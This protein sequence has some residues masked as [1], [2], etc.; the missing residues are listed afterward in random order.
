MRVRVAGVGSYVP[1]VVVTNERLVKAIPGWPAERIEEKTGI[2]ERRY[3]YDFDAEA[4]RSIHPPPSDGPGP[5]VQIAELALRDAL[6]MAG[7][8]GED[9]DG[10][11]MTTCNPDRVHFSQD[12]MELHE[13]MGMRP[14]A[15]ALLHDDGCGGAMFHLARAR[16]L[17][18]SGHRRTIAVVGSNAFSPHL[19]RQ[20][21]SGK[22]ERNGS[23]IGSFLSFYLF[24]DG[25][26]AILLRGGSDEGSPSG[27][28]GSYAANVRTDL[29]MNPGGGNHRLPQPGRSEVTDFAFY[30]DGKLVA[31]TFGPF[32]RKAM[33]GALEKAGV[34]LD[35]I[36]RFYVHQ[37]N[38][39]VLEAFVK[40]N[41]IAMDRVPTHM[42][43]YGNMVSAG[44]LVLLAED[45]RAGNVQ[46]GS[47]QLVMMAALGAGAQFA[48][49]VIRL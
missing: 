5:N 34:K 7:L 47:G 33:D 24:G 14:E 8:S 48:A 27:I 16:E 20:A 12:A 25:A 9:L 30:V 40:E 35:E 42:E 18:E 28:L 1:P 22:M 39:R 32:L 6:A 46:L 17:I 26:G 11:I 43:K 19:D 2:A 23:S 45:L 36:T 10:L 41:G 3:V 4:G 31:A 49:H 38:K 37:A 13:R 15:S 21:Y 44:T 29:V